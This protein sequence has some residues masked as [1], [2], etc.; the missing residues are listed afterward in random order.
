MIHASVQT[1]WMW[2]LNYSVETNLQQ[3]VCLG[4]CQLR[5]SFPQIFGKNGL[6]SP[7]SGMVWSHGPTEQPPESVGSGCGAAHGPNLSADS[8]CGP[9]ET[10]RA[11]FCQSFCGLKSLA[12]LL[13]SAVEQIVF[14]D[15]LKQGTWG[16]RKGL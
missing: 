16:E 13:L 14:S 4:Q 11:F 1:G 3:L 2:G 5:F 8:S 6:E 10:Y 12:T 9:W 7:V 15:T